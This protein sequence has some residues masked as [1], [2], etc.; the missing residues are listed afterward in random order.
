MLSTRELQARLAYQVSTDE[1]RRF[2]R[3][4]YPELF[5]LLPGERSAP[6]HVVD[7]LF[8]LVGNHGCLAELQERLLRRWPGLLTAESPITV[9]AVLSAI[10]SVAALCAMV[11]QLILR[12]IGA[13]PAAVVETTDTELPGETDDGGSSGEA[14]NQTSATNTTDLGALAEDPDDA[15]TTGVRQRS[16]QTLTDLLPL[17][18]RSLR[19]CASHLGGLDFEVVVT[20]NARGRWIRAE[21]LRLSFGE[22]RC[23]SP[24]LERARRRAPLLIADART[25]LRITIP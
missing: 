12:G 6:A 20:S 14:P 9:R 16:P 1:L 4:A 23:I 24:A 22:L 17:I 13:P 11:L 8:R 7:E 10:G 18:H 2:V 3:E 15:P 25:T 5:A 21:P 19:E